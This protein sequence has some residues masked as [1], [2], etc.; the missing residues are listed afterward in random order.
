MR[1]G[2]ICRIRNFYRLVGCSRQVQNSSS[3]CRIPLVLTGIPAQPQLFPSRDRAIIQEEKAEATGRQD[4]SQSEIIDLVGRQ[5]GRV[6]HC[7]IV[8][9]GR[10]VRVHFS[11]FGFHGKMACVLLR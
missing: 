1:M 3:S 4:H 7:L 6:A 8:P 5:A 9:A 2:K 10:N 11:A